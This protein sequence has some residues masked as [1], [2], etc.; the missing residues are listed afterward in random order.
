MGNH[1]NCIN[2]TKLDEKG[3]CCSEDYDKTKQEHYELESTWC[4]N[5]D[6]KV[7]LEW[8]NGN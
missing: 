8:N 3:M 5:Y 4:T 1:D 2:C 6:R 7:C